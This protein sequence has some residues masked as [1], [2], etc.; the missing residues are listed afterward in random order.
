M[1]VATMQAPRFTP[2]IPHPPLPRFITEYA[3]GETPEVNSSQES[4]LNRSSLMDVP[5][6]GMQHQYPLI[7]LAALDQPSFIAGEVSDI[8][9]QSYAAFDMFDENYGNS[10][11]EV[12]CVLL[13]PYRTVT[14][15]R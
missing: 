5:F 15:S 7:Y 11:G 9:M 2:P 8:N 12:L 13:R 4:L 14:L 10:S 6:R 1:F 3:V